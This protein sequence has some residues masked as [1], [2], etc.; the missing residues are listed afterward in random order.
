MFTM[1]VCKRCVGKAS[2]R[3]CNLHRILSG[4]SSPSNLGRRS[5]RAES[6]ARW[7]PG[8][9]VG[10][11]GGQRAGMGLVLGWA[12]GGSQTSVYPV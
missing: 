6:E 11:A 12:W 10:G 8:G 5:T 9:A 2:P 1:P 4:G 7:P 3:W